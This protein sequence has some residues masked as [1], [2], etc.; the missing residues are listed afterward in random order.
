MNFGAQPAAARRDAESTLVPVNDRVQLHIRHFGEGT[1]NTTV[2]VLHDLFA[3]GSLFFRNSDALASRLAHEGFDV[4]VPDLRGKGRSWPALTRE[5]ARDF[6]CDFHRAVTEDLATVF[7]QLREQAPDKPVY[8]VGHGTGGLLW[9]S[10]LARWPMV[11]DTVRGIVLLGT[12]TVRER[13]GLL[14]GW[15]WRVRDGWFARWRSFQYGLVQ[16]TGADGE[17][18]VEATHFYGEI[19]RLLEQ[20]WIDPEDGLDHAAR[21]AALPYWP[22]TLVVT[23]ERDAPWCGPRSAR[24]LQ[25]QLPPHDGRLY[26]FPAAS[27]VRLLGPR[28]ALAGG[29]GAGELQTLVL[30]WLAAFDG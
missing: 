11:R 16:K 4:W 25:A 6:A 18:G 20:G 26:L 13:N 7:G 12:A 2:V 17:P 10:F 22:P 29:A 27:G 15:R 28:S 5:S 21:L 9:L 30:D 19:R 14:A 1:R 3:D 8:L 23:G 24:A